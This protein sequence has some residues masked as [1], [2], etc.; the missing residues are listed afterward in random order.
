MKKTVI[1]FSM[2]IMLTVILTG[3]GGGGSDKTYLTVVGVGHECENKISVNS[4]TFVKMLNDACTSFGS[5]CIIGVEGSPK[6]LFEADIPEPTTSGLSSSKLKSIA[7]GRVEEIM[8]FYQTAVPKTGEVNTL[9]A[10]QLGA[11]SLRGKGEKNDTRVLLIQDSG[12]ST[13][14]PLDFRN[15]L[16]RA[17]SVDEIVEGLRKLGEIPDLTGVTVVW[18]FCGDTAAPQKD[19]TE[20]DKK[21]LKMLWKGI[22]EAAGAE[23]PTD[24]GTA[25]D[26]GYF[27]SDF[28]S[29]IPNTGMPKVSLVEPGKT[30]FSFSKKSSEDIAIEIEPMETAVLDET[31]VRF[32]GDRAVF[33]DEQAAKSSIRTVA[34]NLIA[35]GDSQ[36]YIIGTTATGDRDFCAKL[37]TDRAE[38]VKKVLVEMGVAEER[39]IVY[40]L[41]YW[42][43]WHV[44]DV[45]S[46]GTWYEENASQNRKVMVVDVN[47]EEAE[48]LRSYS[49]KGE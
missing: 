33:V 5:V 27:A 48:L 19:L 44:K 13:V 31:Q 8:N 2:V 41:G 10:L 26:E 14:E 23:K 17:K 42:D 45:D 39:M 4:P 34:D 35:H 21:A 15:G 12:L 24:F 43:P 32:V 30:G 25:F 7:E 3:C 46:K 1:I 16:L 29:G 20:Q 9:R 18:C 40:G 36:V 38:A 11:Q 37:S 47:S 22:L 6:V 49:V 28:S